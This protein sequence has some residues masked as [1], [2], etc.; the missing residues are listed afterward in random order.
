MFIYK[1]KGQGM[2]GLCCEEGSG[3]PDMPNTTGAYLYKNLTV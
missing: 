2:P 3:L 1:Q